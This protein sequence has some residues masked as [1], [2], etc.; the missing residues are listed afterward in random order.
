M[1]KTQ[2][3]DTLRNIRK[4][5]LT[6]LSIICIA[7]IAVTAFLGINFAANGMRQ[8]GDKFYKETSFRDFE[9]AST[10]MLGADDLEDIRKIEGVAAAEGVFQTAGRLSSD[11]KHTDVTAISLTEKINIPKVLTGRLPE[12]ENECALEQDIADKLGVKPGDKVKLT[13]DTGEGMA[14]YMNVTELTVVGTAIHPDHL[15]K[16][17]QTPGRRYVMVTASAF[18]VEE[19]EVNYMKAE[20]LTD[21]G[22]DLNRYSDKYFDRIK[23][24]KEKLKE[25]AAEKAPVRYELLMSQIDELGADSK[26]GIASLKEELEAAESKV[27]KLTGQ[28]EFSENMI[29]MY[30]QLIKSG[31][32]E[33]KSIDKEADAARYT[34]VCESVEQHKRESGLLEKDL[35]DLQKTLAEAQEE[36]SQASLVLETTQALISIT[37]KEIS[38]IKEGNWFIFDMRGNPG[39]LNLSS[40]ADSVSSLSITFSLFFIIIA[41]LVIYTS[42][43][44]IMEEQRKLIGATKALGLFNKEILAK[45]MVF[46]LSAVLIGSLLGVVCGYTVIQ[47]IVL[48]SYKMLYVLDRLTPSLSIPLTLIIITAALILAAAAV[49]LSCSKLL[50][51]TAIQLMQEKQP[52]GGR[53]KAG[54][55]GSLYTRLIFRNIRSDLSRVLVTTVSVAGCC[56][57]L[58]IGF[59]LRN[60]ASSIIDKQY[61]EIIEYDIKV[62]YDGNREGFVKLLDGAGAEYAI[63]ND[64]HRM[65]SVDDDELS[66]AEVFCGDVEK[67]SDLYS[68]TDRRTGDPLPITET[69]VYIQSRAAETNHLKVGD[70]FVIYNEFMSPCKVKVAGIFNNY[71]GF[72]MV[73]S[74]KYY[75]KV[76]NEEPVTNTIL[77]DTQ[78][79]DT[80]AL[81]EQLRQ[82][83]GFRSLTKQ[84]A[85]ANKIQKIVDIFTKVS[86]VMVVVA[87]LMAYFILLNIN[88]MYITRKTRE[89]TVMRIN[90]FTVGEVKRYVLLETI[91]TTIAGIILGIAVG[92]VMG[93]VVIRSIETTYLQFVR[94]IS[95]VA[96][97]LGAVI[98]VIFTL[99]INAIAL[100]KIKHL[101]LTDM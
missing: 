3:K 9:I 22:G 18:S 8:S 40:N 26:E 82:T 87:G 72:Y 41:A 16:P 24:V 62:N 71:V 46:A 57:L 47:G 32:E 29:S 77:I 14:S 94:G 97:G 63:V 75:Q 5:V 74:D 76:F 85:E 38:K 50:K 67:I 10:L 81:S 79:A 36:S 65:F 11:S 56:S 64:E 95:L 31:E 42:V 58:V 35:E 15:A 73:M 49:W 44:R 34:A 86:G 55:S 33:L 66:T 17:D 61:G 96:W 12:N 48:S 28:V 1:K 88:K 90:G 30:Q 37:E 51:S 2:V 21:R 7:G 20:I 52:V 6:W 13:D 19:D 93:Y 69:G 91:A 78:K 54:G 59:T 25:L 53:S 43:G 84:E 60:N 98:T 27:K 45:Y 68:L 92:S 4:N 39:Y 80:E 23:G 99:G 83:E 100:K 101:K 70:S 89:L